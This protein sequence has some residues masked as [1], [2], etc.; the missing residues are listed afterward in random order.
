[1]AAIPDARGGTSVPKEDTSLSVPRSITGVDT[2]AYITRHPKEEW[3]PGREVGRVGDCELVA[4]TG[5]CCAVGDLPLTDR[6]ARDLPDDIL[7]CVGLVST[8][9]EKLSRGEV[10]DGGLAKHREF[11]WFSHL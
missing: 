3:H 8:L 5:D 6:V 1:M 2:N 10:P 11:N 7:A 4:T 9:P